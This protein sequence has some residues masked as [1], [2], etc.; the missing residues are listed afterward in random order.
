MPSSTPFVDP[1]TGLLDR[2]QLRREAG[3]LVKLVGLFG[4]I[5]LLP[6]LV[7]IVLGG[8]TLTFV[9][10]V[11]AWFVLA[12]GAAIT[13]MY[14]IARAIGLSDD[15]SAHARVRRVPG[16]GRT[17]EPEAGRDDF[18]DDL[19]GGTERGEDTDRD[20]DESLDSDEDK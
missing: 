19:S 20:G 7:A 10:T 12:V 6:V 11:F 15:E 18:V 16:D 1:E 8:P 14:V 2:D 5:A 3:P 17:N 9:S 4:T 13:L